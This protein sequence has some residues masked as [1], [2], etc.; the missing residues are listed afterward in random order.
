M[1]KTILQFIDSN[2]PSW[3]PNWTKKK[4]QI[5]IMNLKNKKEEF[6]IDVKNKIY[7][8]IVVNDI[9]YFGSRDKHIYAIN[10]L[11]GKEHWKFETEN[12]IESSPL[13]NNNVLFIGSNDKYFYALDATTGDK[14][15]R[16]KMDESAFGASVIFQNLIIFSGG[17]DKCIYALNIITGEVVWKFV[18][19]GWIMSTPTL[20]NN[21]VYFGSNDKHLYALDANTGKEIWKFKSGDSVKTSPVLTEGLVYIGSNDAHIYAIDISTGKEKWKYKTQEMWADKKLVFNNEML[22]VGGKYLYAIN[23]ITGEEIWKTSKWPTMV[24]FPVSAIDENIYVHSTDHKIYVM[25]SK[26][27]NEKWNLEVGYPVYDRHSFFG[28]LICLPVEKNIK[29]ENANKEFENR[30]KNLKYFIDKNKNIH[31]EFDFTKEFSNYFKID[32]EEGCIEMLIDTKEILI[33]EDYN[34]F[35]SKFFASD[36]GNNRGAGMGISP[37]EDKFYKD[38]FNIFKDEDNEVETE[39]YV[40]VS[41]NFDG[42]IEGSVTLKEDGL[43]WEMEDDDDGDD[44]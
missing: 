3:S 24:A 21:A 29:N 25:D 10:I 37:F 14:I 17:K 7:N 26:T 18:T 22:F 28:E 41:G 8:S 13:V 27:G 31:N 34:N 6:I 19:E 15:W 11:T 12:S 4:N 5:S 38:L 23:A 32:T 42:E 44:W 1:A 30:V 43:H 33:P 2:G 39:I 20:Y 35:L 16:F 9:I 36:I 40:S